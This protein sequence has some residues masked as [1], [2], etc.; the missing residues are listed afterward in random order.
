[1]LAAAIATAISASAATTA[2]AASAEALLWDGTVVTTTSTAQCAALG[3][4][5]GSTRALF[6]PHLKISDPKAGVILTFDEG[7]AMVIRATTNTRQMQGTNA[8]YCGIFFDPS[9]GESRTWF[10]GTYTF[11]VTPATV[12]ASTNEVRVTGTVTKF[13]DIVGCTVTFRAAFLRRIP[14]Q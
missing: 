3:D 12:T 10:G 11:T 2:G 4:L 8:P 9:M 7:G 6:R 13:A 1:M 14:N 5:T